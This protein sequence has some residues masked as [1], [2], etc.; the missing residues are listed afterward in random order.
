[1]ALTTAQVLQAVEDRAQ[2]RAIQAREIRELLGNSSVTFA[3]I[4]Y[5]TD[6]ALAARHRDQ[7]VVKV[8]SA[9]VQLAATLHA[10]TQLYSRAVRRSAARIAE[11]SPEQVA[12][13]AATETYYEHLDCHCLVQHRKQP[14][15]VYLYAIFN[16]AASQYVREGTIISLEEVAS[17]STPSQARELLQPQE[18]VYNH[19]HGIHHRVHVRVIALANLVEIRARRQLLHI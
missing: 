18:T 17:L 16:H 8:T 14:E 9:N 13:F 7:R 5:A 10:H 4:L 1:M 3:Q 19:T 15:R 6:V 12:A 11:N 2:G